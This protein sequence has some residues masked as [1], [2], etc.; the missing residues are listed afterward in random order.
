MPAHLK[1]SL[2]KETM[3]PG[4]Y[5]QMTREELK[6][7]MRVFPHDQNTSGFFIAVI[8]KLKEFDQIDKDM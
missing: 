6:K 2:I 3:F 8:R 4:F 5:E 1:G 7:C